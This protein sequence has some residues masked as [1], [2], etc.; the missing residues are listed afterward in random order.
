V[1]DAF[2]TV[3]I[4]RQKIAGKRKKG[5]GVCPHQLLVAPLTRW[6]SLGYSRA[7]SS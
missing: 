3:R 4:P 2:S 6:F 1:L 7:G 5:S